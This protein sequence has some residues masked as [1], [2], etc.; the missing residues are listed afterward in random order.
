MKR[1]WTGSAFS[2]NESA[3][4]AIVM[5]PQ[6]QAATSPAINPRPTKDSGKPGFRSVSR[7]ILGQNPSVSKP[8]LVVICWALFIDFEAH[9]INSSKMIDNFPQD[10]NFNRLSFP[11]V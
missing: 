9:S 11:Y 10:L 3:R 2:T 6:S 7:E 5:G 8:I 4:S 1:T